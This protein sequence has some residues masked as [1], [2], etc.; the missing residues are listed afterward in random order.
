MGKL[1][2]VVGAALSLGVVAVGLGLAAVGAGPVAQP[3]E[4]AKQP[5]A[6]AADL[7]DG[8]EVR[9]GSAA[10]RHPDVLTHLRFTADGRHLL[11]YG[12]GK[13]RRWDAT[14]GAAVPDR[15]KDID[16]TYGPTMLS[17]DAARVVAP[18]VDG[19]PTRRSVREYDLATG[20]HTELFPVPERRPSGYYGAQQ[21]VLSPDGTLLVEGWSNEAFIWDLKARVVRHRL[22]FPSPVQRLLTPDGQPLF[23]DGA[24]GHF[25]F[26]PD[27]RHLMTAGAD[28]RAVQFWDVATWENPNQ[29]GVRELAVSPDDR[30]LAAADNA[31]LYG[32]GTEVAVWDLTTDG[33]PRVVTVPD[34]LGLGGTLAFSPG[35]ALYVVSDPS[36]H[37]APVTTVVTRWDA[38]TGRRVGR[39]AGPHPGRYGSLVAAVSPDG[40]TLAVGT[41]WGVVQQYDTRTGAEVARAS[42]PAAEVIGASFGPDGPRVPSVPTGRSPTGTP[43][44]VSPFPG[45]VR[46]CPRPRSAPRPRWCHRTAGGRSRPRS[47]RAGR[48]PRSARPRRGWWTCGTGRPASGRRPSGRTGRSGS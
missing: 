42:S 25:V 28:D 35:G 23:P 41:Y 2:K 4:P 29:R 13:L 17:P 46:L 43:R 44:P 33:P 22:R 1:A 47:T 5:G 31:Y 45:G 10:L 38:A 24:T 32:V 18:H 16:T 19:S 26:T 27:G 8:A 39:W 3:P 48:S 15:A 11:T 37:S 20:R 12:H 34:G 6:P 30:W 14:T 21:F 7:P 36:R 40:N 9:L